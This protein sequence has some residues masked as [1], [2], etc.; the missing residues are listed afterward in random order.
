MLQELGI[1][2]AKWKQKRCEWLP[3]SRVSSRTNTVWYR[4]FCVLL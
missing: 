1:D 3:E 2:L 4:V